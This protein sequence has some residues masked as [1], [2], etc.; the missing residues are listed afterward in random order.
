MT[1]I[2]AKSTV[3]ITIE[4]SLAVGTMPLSVGDD[5]NNQIQK[6]E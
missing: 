5:Q 1:S 6:E 4:A 2:M 3:T